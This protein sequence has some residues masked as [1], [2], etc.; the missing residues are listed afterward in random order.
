MGLVRSRGLRVRLLDR[1]VPNTTDY[2]IINSTGPGLSFHSTVT[3]AESDALQCS[4]DG[5]VGPS[6][7]DS[8]AIQRAQCIAGNL[9]GIQ[10]IVHDMGYGIP[11]TDLFA[12]T[13]WCDSTLPD[14]PR[15]PLVT[16]PRCWVAPDAVA[17]G[18]V[19]LWYGVYVF[20][21]LSTAITDCAATSRVIVVVGSAD[22]FGTGDTTPKVYT[23]VISATVPL[24][25]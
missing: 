18:A 13:I 4:R 11:Q 16:P 19:H 1:C 9:P 5:G 22:P 2:C 3:D 10:G 15:C 8:A 21:S 6:F 25:G 12:E 23:E 20:G 14:F 7:P 24:I 17:A